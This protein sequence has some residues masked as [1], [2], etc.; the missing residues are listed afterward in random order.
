[1]YAKFEEGSYESEKAGAPRQQHGL[2]PHCRR[3]PGDVGA[4]LVPHLKNSG[5]QCQNGLLHAAF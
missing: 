4:L 2:D 5:K 3:V 1:M